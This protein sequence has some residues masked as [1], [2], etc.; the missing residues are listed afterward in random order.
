MLGFKTSKAS[1][2]FFCCSSI[3][4]ICFWNALPSEEY[5][6]LTCSIILLWSDGNISSPVRYSY[7]LILPD[8]NADILTASLFILYCSFLSIIWW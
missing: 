7:L 1:T 8:D 3:V 2:Y 5:V 4:F 6:K